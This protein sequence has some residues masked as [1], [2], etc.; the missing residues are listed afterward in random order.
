MTKKIRMGMIRK[1]ERY[2]F[3]TEKFNYK[4]EE[5]TRFYKKEEDGFVYIGWAHGED[6]LKRVE[7]CRLETFY[8]RV[9]KINKIESL[10]KSKNK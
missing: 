4:D 1:T 5:Y 2:S 6:A 7:A 3:Q 8:Q 9:T 10:N